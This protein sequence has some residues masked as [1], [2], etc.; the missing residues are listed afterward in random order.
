MKKILKVHSPLLNHC[1]ANAY[2][3]SVIG[4]NEQEYDWIMSNFINLRI[5]PY[6]KYDDFYR[7]DMWYN[8]PFIIDHV[9]S[10]DL[11]DALT[12][13]VVELFIKLINNNYYIYCYLNQSCIPCYHTKKNE[14]HNAF[15]YGYDKYEKKFYFSDFIDR[16][17]V[18][19]TCTFQEL[20]RA[21]NLEK[22]KSEE[23]QKVSNFMMFHAF[24]KIE[25]DYEFKGLSNIRPQL[26][27]Y[28]NATNKYSDGMY[29]FHSNDLDDALL[30]NIQHAFD[31]KFGLEF[32]D[33]LEH[34]ICES[35]NMTRAYHLLYLS[36][37]LMRKRIFYYQ[38]Q[39]LS[40]GGN[41]ILEMCSKLENDSLILRNVYIKNKLK[42]DNSVSCTKNIVRLLK[43]LKENDTILINK[44]IDI[45]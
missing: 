45:F 8:C 26:I 11:I 5:N 27:D 14:T 24:K 12:D 15:V 10:R 17:L 40:F 3:L 7:F 32:Y 9:I 21:Y 34:L 30:R 38:K 13:D 29:Y 23:I 42:K 41:D 44:I 4:E 31:F 6:T 39:G 33:I 22:E 36:K 37:S 16:K 1:P 25:Y 28:L 43:E 19:N 2:L 20:D 18:F 35:Y